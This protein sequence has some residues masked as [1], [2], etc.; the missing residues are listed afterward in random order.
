MI[1]DLIVRNA[2]IDTRDAERPEAS[3]LA[4]LDGRV[5]ALDEQL[6]GLEARETIDAGGLALLPGFN[7]VHAHSVWFGTTL[8][9][10]DLSAVTSLDDIYRVI[11]AQAQ[12]TEAGAWVV[13][14][15][16]NPVLL[17]STHPDRDRL[18][19]AS[20]GR[21][22]WIKHASGHSGQAST[23]GLAL[24][25]VDDRDVP[26]L[27][28]GVIRVD[29]AGR[30]T[31]V[32]EERAMT[33]VQDILLPYPLA[34]IER[35]LALATEHYAR[36]GLTSVTD[37][38]V[39]GGWIGH[40][41]AELAAYQSA[42]D[43]GLLRTR[44][45]VMPVMDALQAI[46]GHADEAARRGF[47]AGMRT[48]WGDDWLQ[49][50][51]VKV[52]TDGSILGRTAQMREDYEGCPGYH[53]Y[54]QDDPEIMRTRVLEA[55]AAGW[56]LALHAVGDAAL[57]FALDAIEEAIRANGTP[58]VPNR[59]EHGMVVRPDQLERLAALQVACVVQPSFIPS[60]GEGI[61]G[62]VGQQRGEWSIRARSQLDAGLPLAFSSDRPVAPGAPL[63]GIQSFVERR[64]EEG[65]DYGAHERISVD[66]AV[67]AA[68]VG[69]S[70]VTGQ[71]ARKGRLA[72]GQL[73]DMVLLDAHPREVAVSDI[74]AIPVRATLAGGAFTHRDADVG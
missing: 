65:L 38:G 27:E 63:L 24:A 5:V 71:Q 22:V 73:A 11:E 58:S 14:A 47:G 18:D 4:V 34:T 19:A 37:A 31:G 39:A 41:P 64:S 48:G 52:F 40:A 42:R 56:S 44:M 26:A 54:L 15:G 74:H 35:A 13:A 8:M 49:L 72:P 61:R 46:P 1:V 57:D 53:G 59:V 67:H 7:D 60:F 45:Q 33:L 68:T 50:G 32:L 30:P 2:R 6:D 70:E 10:A 3:A 25:G 9:D 55:A 36:E 66:E 20:G 16:Y 62:P 23:A 21:P 28:G 69:S 17:G 51:P 43:A 29:D 12:T